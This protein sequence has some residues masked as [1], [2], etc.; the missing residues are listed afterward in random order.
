M[1]V[2]RGRLFG[3][4]GQAEYSLCQKNVDLFMKSHGYNNMDLLDLSKC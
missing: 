2:L 4:V 1:S 3:L